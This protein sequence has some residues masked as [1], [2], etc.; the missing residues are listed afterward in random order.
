MNDWFDIAIIGSGP[1]G[2]SAALALKNSKARIALFDKNTFPREKICGDGLCDRS[3]NVLRTI[4]ENYFNEFIQ[5]LTPLPIHKTD[6]VYKGR[7]HTLSFKNFGYTCK[8]SDFDAFLHNKVT[9]DCTHIHICNN[10]PIVSAQKQNN[11]IIL[12]DKQGNTYKAKMV[13]V[14]NGAKST[15]AQSLHKS[16]WNKS[17]NGVA[18]RAYFENV[19]DLSL[20]TIELHYKKEFFPG[21]FWVFPMPNNIANV[22]FGCN[23][24]NKN[25]QEEAIKDIFHAWILKDPILK[26]R[27]THAHMCSSLKGGLIPYNT[28]NF[29][30]A[31]DS[32]MITGDAASLIDPISG[33]GIG[34]AMLSGY[35]AAQVAEKSFTTQTYSYELTQEY[36]SL[37]QNRISKEIKTRNTIQKGISKFPFGLDVLAAMAKQ[38]NVLQKVSNWYLS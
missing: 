25:L 8:R 4:D 35:F 32:Y 37:L 6:L 21:Y 22:G 11:G 19:A 36:E 9:R 7:H 1:A 26:K 29:A 5:E 31:G 23:I 17:E 20:N 28:N 34:S 27:F 13:I 18:V 38:S 16:L 30:C 33:G 14:A 2:S 24:T 3:I 10:T 15:I 12:H